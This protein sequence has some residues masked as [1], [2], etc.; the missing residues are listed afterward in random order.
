MARWTTPQ[1]GLY[2]EVPLGEEGVIDASVPSALGQVLSVEPQALN[3]IACAFWPLVTDEPLTQLRQQPISVEL[4]TLDLLR[5]KVWTA[6]GQADV[7]VPHSLRRYELF[8]AEGWIGAKVRGS[9]IMVN[10]LRAYR[11]LLPW[12]FYPDSYLDG[13]L[14]PGTVRPCA[15]RSE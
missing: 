13:L 8:R 14:V 15:L 1:A 10:L 5:R 2:F 11:G 12:D 6:L 3:G 4:V 9:G 7:N